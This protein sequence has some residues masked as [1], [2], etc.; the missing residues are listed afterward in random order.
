M[1]GGEPKQRA[2]Q[3]VAL[4]EGSGRVRERCVGLLAGF[5]DPH[6]PP[7]DELPAPVDQ[8]PVEPRVEAV[9]VAQ[10]RPVLPCPDRRVVDG[11]LGIGRTPEQCP[12]EPTRRLQAS[13][14]QAIEEERT[15]I[16][17]RG[18]AKRAFRGPRAQ[19]PRLLTPVQML[20]RPGP[21]N[22]APEGWLALECSVARAGPLRA[23]SARGGSISARGD[24][25]PAPC[26]I[27]GPR[28]PHRARRGSPSG[29]SVHRAAP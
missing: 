26:H 21:F 16:A 7:P 27:R 17:R 14:D 24:E 12:R 25:R 23:K 15:V 19:A 9:D 1:V 11:I 18:H 13:L 28:V 22:P 10:L 20:G 5:D 8:N 2:S 4:V 6:L 29:R 3:R